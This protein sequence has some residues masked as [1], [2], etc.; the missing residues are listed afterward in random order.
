M[1]V[2]ISFADLAP[3]GRRFSPDDKY[4]EHRIK[5]SAQ[6]MVCPGLISC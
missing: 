1:L 4:S 6:N 3:A 5:P 2:D